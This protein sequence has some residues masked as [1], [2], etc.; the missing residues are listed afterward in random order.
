[1]LSGLLP[2][3]S[4]FGKPVQQ[5]LDLRIQAGAHAGVGDQ[6][7]GVDKVAQRCDRP[8]GQL[9]GLVGRLVDVDQRDKA[10]LP[11]DRL[12]GRR[13]QL[14]QLGPGGGQFGRRCGR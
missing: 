9:P 12:P 13:G 2:L 7:H 10:D 1:M 8:V 14:F 6:R 5:R 3:A 11:Q 4:D